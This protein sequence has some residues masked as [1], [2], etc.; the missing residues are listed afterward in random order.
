M[1]YPTANVEPDYSFKLIPADGVY[2]VETFLGNKEYK[3]MLYIGTRPT[4]ETGGKRVVEVN[5]FQFE[6]DLYGEKLSI[7]FKYRIR[8]DLKFGS[9]ELLSDQISR[10]KEEALRLLG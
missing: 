4:L 9:R 3:S 2:A 10:D 7:R 8:G 6:G 5:L 1:G